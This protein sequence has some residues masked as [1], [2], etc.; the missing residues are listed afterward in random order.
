MPQIDPGFVPPST[1]LPAS[2]HAALVRA[3]YFAGSTERHQLPSLPAVFDQNNLQCCVSCA[4]SAALEI[5]NPA[6]PAL[7]PLFHYYVARFD[8]AGASASGQMGLFDGLQAASTFGICTSAQHSPSFSHSGAALKPS[9]AAY[10]DGRGRRIPRKGLLPG[11]SPI[12]TASRV[13]T[14]REQLRRNRP[15]L[16]GFSL[17][18]GYK[19]TI[20]DASHCWDDPSVPLSGTG[21]CVLAVGFDDV[22]Q[23][24]RIQDSQGTGTFDAGRWWMG[25]AV[26]DSSIVSA[27][28]T[29]L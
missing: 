29:L 25:Y 18:A 3:A 27:T 15:V 21:H 11:F 22:R 6:W 5:R 23:A 16:L 9:A 12:G 28:Y 4:V 24:L 8:L 2:E 19:S 17:P 10:A 1:P 14:I 20:P 13:V 26:A 7:S